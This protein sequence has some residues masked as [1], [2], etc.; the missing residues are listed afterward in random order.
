MSE[1]DASGLEDAE[2]EKINRMVMNTRG[3][4]LFSR[5]IVLFEGPTEEYALPVF[6]TDWW[7]MNA[8][9]CGISFVGV[10]G[11][12]NYLPYL[13]MAKMCD[14]PWYVFA[15]GEPAAVTSLKRQMKHIDITDIDQAPNILVLPNGNNFEKYLVEQGYEDAICKMLDTYWDKQDFITTYIEQKHGQ[16]A[17]GDIE[18]DYHSDGGRDRALVDALVTRKVGYAKRLA[19]EILDLDSDQRRFP[20]MVRS[21]LETMS[22]NLGLPREA[23]SV[24]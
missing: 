17:K 9:M 20:Q 2:I 4:I 11:D 14:I 1:I 13:R 5:A 16:K 6:A 15:D 18:R 8:H 19:A 7:G 10:G 3:E 23:R 22:V 24:E 21:L 12:R